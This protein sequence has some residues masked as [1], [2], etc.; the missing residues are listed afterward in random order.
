MH[1]RLILLYFASDLLEILY[2]VDVDTEYH[3]VSKLD[4][5]AIS[6]ILFLIF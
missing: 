6:H 5:H 1:K 2:G 4:T 3:C